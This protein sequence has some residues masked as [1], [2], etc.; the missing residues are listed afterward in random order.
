MSRF[1]FS[2]MQ[3]RYGGAFILEEL[4]LLGCYAVLLGEYILDAS[5]DN[6]ISIIRVKHSENIFPLGCLTSGTTSL[7]TQLHFT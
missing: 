1:L 7:N 5:K 3:P 6:I 2:G 4:R